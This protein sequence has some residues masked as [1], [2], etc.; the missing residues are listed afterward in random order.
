M[1]IDPVVLTQDLVRCPSVTPEDAGVFDV[2]S[3]ALEAVGF[4]CRRMPFTEAG[5]PDVEN[6]FATIGTGG[7]HF[8]FAGHLD[9]VPAGKGWTLDPFAAEIRDGVMF[10]RGT[11]D[12]KSAVAAFI[13]AAG[14]FISARGEDFGGR[15]SLIVTG[16]E[17]GPA[18]NGTTKM[19][20]QLQSDKA[21]PDVCVVGEPTCPNHFGETIKIGR[22]GSLTA[23]VTVLGTQGHVAYPDQADNPVHRLVKVLAALTA[24]PLD[25]GNAYFPPS[26]LSV[27]TFDVGNPATNVIPASASATFNVRF[28]TEQTSESLETWIRGVV[29]QYAPHVDVKIVCSAEPFCTPPGALSDLV[30]SAVH[31]VTGMTPELSTTGGTSDARFV[32][33]YCPVVEYGLVGKSIHKV[34][35]HTLVSDIHALTAV[36]TR[37]L[38]RYFD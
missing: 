24:K 19:L 35:E 3:R 25:D 1:A 13:A 26:T 8:A 18:I 7:R 38:E 20:A 33:T 30:S 15:I 2:A 29:A 5:T 27:T 9:V 4:R 6:L 17:E 21:L 16:D 22:R 34:D 12:M 11:A 32:K 31:D 23:Y 10:G 14:D 36:Y 28:N 37:I